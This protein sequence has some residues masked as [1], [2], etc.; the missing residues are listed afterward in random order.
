MTHHSPG[1]RITAINRLTSVLS[2][3]KRLYCQSYRFPA[4]T[5]QYYGFLT[6]SRFSFSR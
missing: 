2:T 3:V 4:F 6:V 1:L 5:S